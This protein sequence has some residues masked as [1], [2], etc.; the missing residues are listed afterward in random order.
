MDNILFD[1]SAAEDPQGSF[2][3]I[4]DPVK[5]FAGSPPEIRS[6]IVS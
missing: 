1:R 6:A 3:G 4:K 2:V 5:T